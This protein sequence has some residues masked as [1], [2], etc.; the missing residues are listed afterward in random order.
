MAV[1]DGQQLAVEI[2][3]LE[4]DKHTQ[5]VE[6]HASKHV[7]TQMLPKYNTQILSQID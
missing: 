5:V 7:I 3:S 4:Q 2:R 1:A 6:W